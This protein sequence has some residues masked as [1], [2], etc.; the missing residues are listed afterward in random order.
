MG[1]WSWLKVFDWLIPIPP[2]DRGTKKSPYSGDEMSDGKRLEEHKREAEA[3]L[4]RDLDKQG[5]V[6]NGDE[7]SSGTR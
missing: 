3:A 2:T 7:P 4:N 5:K 6:A 1:F